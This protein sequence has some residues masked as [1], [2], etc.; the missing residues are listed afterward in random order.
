MLS[1]KT[2]IFVFFNGESSLF[3]SMR[4]NVRA[5]RTLWTIEAD[6]VKRP[7]AVKAVGVVRQ[8]GEEPERPQRFPT[9]KRVDWCALVFTVFASSGIEK[10]ANVSVVIAAPVPSWVEGGGARPGESSPSV[11]CWKFTGSQLSVKRYNNEGG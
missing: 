10:A 6:V 2:D 9:G 7:R 4:Q 11:A 5:W 3:S 8:G 1:V